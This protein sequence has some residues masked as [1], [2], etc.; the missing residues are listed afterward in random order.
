MILQAVAFGI[1]FWPCLIQVGSLLG[2]LKKHHP[3]FICHQ[4]KNA[5]FQWDDGYQ[6]IFLPHVESGIIFLP[7]KS[8]SIQK[9]PTFQNELPQV[10]V[11]TIIIGTTTCDHH[12]IS[13]W[14]AFNTVAVRMPQLE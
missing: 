5:T 13:R 10:F 11:S 9:R 6:I 3:V 1:W 12:D 7:K 2:S 14:F 4:E 8:P